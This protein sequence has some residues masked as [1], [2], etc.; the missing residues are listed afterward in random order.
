MATAAMKLKASGAAKRH[1]SRA[2]QGGSQAG[3]QAGREGQHGAGGVGRRVWAG[4]V[5]QAGAARQA[6]SAKAWPTLE[7]GPSRPEQA[8]PSQSS[9]RAGLIRPGQ[10]QPAQGTCLNSTVSRRL[11]DGAPFGRKQSAPAC[12]GATK[13]RGPCG[14]AWGRQLQWRR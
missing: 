10:A 3:K 6:R 11:C 12:R 1:I 8:R 5:L 7:A 13:H 9:T 2:A 14:Q 4:G